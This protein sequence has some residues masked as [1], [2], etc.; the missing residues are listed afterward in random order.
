MSTIAIAGILLL[1]FTLPL[2]ILRHPFQ[3]SWANYVLDTLDGDLLV[4]LGMAPETYQT[5]DK[6]ADWVTYVAMFVAGRRWEIRRTIALTPI[7][8]PS[9]P[10]ITTCAA[11]LSRY[12][13]VPTPTVISPIVNSWPSGESGWTSP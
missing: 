2:L 12:S 5:W 13:T 8:R 7:I 11:A 3:A 9:V 1:K 10:S 4:P 6:A